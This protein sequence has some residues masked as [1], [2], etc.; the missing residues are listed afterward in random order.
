VNK[1]RL[2]KL[3]DLL[4][5]DAKNKKGVAFDLTAWAKKKCDGD[6]YYSPYS[7]QREEKVEVSCNT[8]ACAWGLGAISGVFKKQGVAYEITEAG[9]LIPTYAGSHD[10]HAATRPPRRCRH[11][12]CSSTERDPAPARSKERWRAL[13]QEFVIV[14][15]KV[16]PPE[17]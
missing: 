9:M 16:A 5:A 10:I 13:P 7:F 4:E 17:D 15:G 1:K 2:L 6:D 14:A 12:F 11:E 8:A 3:A